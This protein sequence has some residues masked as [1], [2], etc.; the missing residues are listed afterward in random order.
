M[1]KLSEKAKKKDRKHQEQRKRIAREQLAAE[2][3]KKALQ[4]RVRGLANK[5]KGK[6]APHREALQELVQHPSFPSLPKIAHHKCHHTIEKLQIWEA[7]ANSTLDD[8]SATSYALNLESVGEDCKS[9]GVVRS[10][11]GA[12]LKIVSKF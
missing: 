9:V 10:S 3:E 2:R 8:K 12:L 7:D 11:V 1:K 5:V 4:G 6:V